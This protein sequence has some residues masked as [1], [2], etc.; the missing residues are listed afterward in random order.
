MGRATLATRFRWQAGWCDALGSP[1]W[2]EMLRRGA[3]EIEAGGPLWQVLSGSEAD[4]EESMVQ[5]RLMGALHRLALAGEAPELAACLPSTG[6]HGRPDETWEAFSATVA[7]RAGDLRELARSP[8]QTNEVGRCRA[9]AP[10]FAEIAAATGLPLRLLELGSSAG[11]LLRWDRY[12][13]E[14]GG[15]S[16]GD[17]GSVVRFEGSLDG[18]PPRADVVVAERAGCD[19]RPVDPTTAAGRLTLRSYVWPDQRERLRLLE[20]ALD[21]AASTPAQVDRAGAAEWLEPRLAEPVPGVCTVVFHSIVMQYVPEPERDA[22]ASM[23][24]AAGARATPD[25][26]LAHLALEPGGEEAHLRLTLWPGEPDRLLA[27]CGYHGAPVTW[28]V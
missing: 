28:N 3:D 1:L 25:A 7:S 14:L 22:I 2:G 17:P 24:A 21:V 19:P 18:E 4:P 8:V 15:W 27:T 5:L 11:L 10:G 20:A 23:L 26:P 13:Y 16:F 9:L 12:R 6:G